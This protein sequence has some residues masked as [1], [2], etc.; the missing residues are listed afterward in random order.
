MI[1]RQ[2]RGRPRGRPVLG[3][4]PVE[5]R[6]KPNGGRGRLSLGQA[7]GASCAIVRCHGTA[8]SHPTTVCFSLTSASS[9]P[10]VDFQLSLNSETVDAVDPD[11]PLAVTADTS[12]RDLLLLMK[13]QRSGGVVICDDG[14][15]VGIFTERDALRL[16][17]QKSDLSVPVEQVM[18]RNVSTLAAD[19]TVGKAIQKMSAGGYRRLPIVD[20]DA[21]P[22]G[23]AD[24]RGI[25]HYLVQHFPAAIYNLPPN[26]K[27]KLAEREGA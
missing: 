18:A 6:F 8:R 25:V 19:S 22:Q 14:K 10:A 27:P 21:V 17:A 12:L 2:M 11:Q 15:M 5:L 1:Q 4:I 24:V 7:G 3:K 26:P 13:A 9:F 16:M 20:G 23:I